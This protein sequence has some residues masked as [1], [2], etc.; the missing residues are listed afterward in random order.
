[1]KGPMSR[2]KDKGVAED[3]RGETSASVEWRS[4]V[5]FHHLR[6]RW[7]WTAPA[8]MEPTGG[9]EERI[10]GWTGSSSAL[11]EV[12]AESIQGSFLPLWR[13]GDPRVVNGHPWRW[14]SK[15]LLESYSRPLEPLR[16]P[17][18]NASDF[19]ASSGK[20]NPFPQPP[21]PPPFFTFP[22]HH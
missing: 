14:S 15:S 1:M 19:H 3:R 20:K 18:S 8:V 22:P 4:T 2:C 12:K 21:P 17:G 5:L 6:G 13:S 10:N 16:Y 7:V 9:N 11:T